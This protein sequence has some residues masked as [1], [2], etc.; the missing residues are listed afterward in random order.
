M[1]MVT[2]GKAGVFGVKKDNTIYHRTG[3][4]ADN[5]SKGTEWQLLS[6]SLKYIACGKTVWGVN[7][8]DDIY[9]MKD[10]VKDDAGK[11]T[12]EWVKVDGKL[13]QL[14]VTQGI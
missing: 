5:F 8:G 7:S 1:K 6:G 12:F 2:S 13:S 9:Y 10:L 14:S 11:L 4:Y 3:T